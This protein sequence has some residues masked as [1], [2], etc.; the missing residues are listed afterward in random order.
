M[1][2]L[3]VHNLG[4]TPF[5]RAYTY[6]MQYLRKRIAGQCPDTLLVTEH[7]PVITVGRGGAG[8]SIRASAEELAR[9]N[10]PVIFADR[11]GKA[12]VHAPGQLVAY[13][14]F[15]L[16]LHGKNVHRFIRDLESALKATIASY[17]VQCDTHTPATGVW[18]N[19]RKIASIGIAVRRWVSYHGISLNLSMDL[20]L[21]ELIVPCGV[22]DMRLINLSM[23]SPSAPPHRSVVRRFSEAITRLFHFDGYTIHDRAEACV[24]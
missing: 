21:F 8:D 12:T 16:R 15:D 24:A 23:L 3:E 11:G 6:Q 17:G 22:T 13:P 5:S 7:S 20:K 19:G 2:A 4:T 14:I 18:T 1:K 10:I 9:K